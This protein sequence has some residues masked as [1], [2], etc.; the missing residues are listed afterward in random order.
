MPKI[1]IPLSSMGYIFLNFILTSL[2]F[3]YFSLVPFPSLSFCSSH[4]PFFIRVLP[5][6]CV[7]FSSY[8]VPTEWYPV[9]PHLILS[10]VLDLQLHWPL[11][12]KWFQNHFSGFSPLFGIHSSV[13]ALPC[14]VQSIFLSPV[15]SN[16]KVNHLCSSFSYY[17]VVFLPH[18]WILCLPLPLFNMFPVIDFKTFCAIKPSVAKIKIHIFKSFQDVFHSLGPHNPHSAFQSQHK[19]SSSSYLDLN[20]CIGPEAAHP[21]CCLS[22]GP[23]LKMLYLPFSPLAHPWSSGAERSRHS[24]EATFFT[25]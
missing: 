20:I 10:R 5:H 15:P 7:F 17:C 3:L 14:F 21:S 8:Y 23:L 9:C 16:L 11:A 4:P 1:N 19:K 12:L 18:Y 6:C 25:E 2:P 13:C 22:M 24:K